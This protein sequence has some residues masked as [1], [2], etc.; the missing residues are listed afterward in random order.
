MLYIY[1]DSYIVI[2]SLDLLLFSPLL[3]TVLVMSSLLA[4]FSLPLF[5][6][7][8]DSPRGLQPVPSLTPIIKTFPLTMSWSCHISS[9]YKD[10]FKERMTQMGKRKKCL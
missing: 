8:L 10:N 4:M 7:V 9:L 5:P 1:I 6:T 2:C 3:E